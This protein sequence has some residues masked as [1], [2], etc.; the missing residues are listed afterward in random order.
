[1]NKIIPYLFYAAGSFFIFLS[2][3]FF[4]REYGN[5]RTLSKLDPMSVSVY[6]CLVVLGS[7][8]VYAG[9]KKSGKG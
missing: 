6:F 4:A 7:A 3:F 8:L 5:V 2:W 1:M 9:R